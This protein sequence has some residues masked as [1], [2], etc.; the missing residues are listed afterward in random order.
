MADWVYQWLCGRLSFWQRE[1]SWRIMHIC[2]LSRSWWEV[3]DKYVWADMMVLLS[4]SSPLCRQIQFWGAASVADHLVNVKQ[5]I[6]L[7]SLIRVLIWVEM[8][9]STTRPTRVLQQYIGVCESMQPLWIDLVYEWSTS[10]SNSVHGSASFACYV[11]AAVD[12]SS[13]SICSYIGCCLVVSECW[14]YL[15]DH[16][17]RA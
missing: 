3:S 6:V 14:I 5:Q 12:Q 16:I 7:K 10:E 2:H 11:L 8:M 15:D 1:S 17:L 4:F 9:L 13:S